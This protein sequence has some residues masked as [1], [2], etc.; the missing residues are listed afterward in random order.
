MVLEKIC[1]NEWVKLFRSRC[2]KHIDLTQKDFSLLLQ[3]TSYGFNQKINQ[4]F[5]FDFLN[6]GKNGCFIPLK[7]KKGLYM[8]R[9]N[10]TIHSSFGSH[11]IC[12]NSNYFI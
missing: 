3:S 4:S 8:V 2:E 9:I 10:S 5:Q 6:V 1:H 11:S 12:C 7:V